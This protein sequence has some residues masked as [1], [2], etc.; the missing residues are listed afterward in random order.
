MFESNECNV[1]LNREVIL[2]YIVDAKKLMK[3]YVKSG[4]YPNKKLSVEEE[5]RMND[6]LALKIF[7]RKNSALAVGFTF[8]KD[9]LNLHLVS[10]MYLFSDV[11][12][13]INGKTCTAVIK[14]F[15]RETIKQFANNLVPIFRDRQLSDN[16]L[17]STYTMKINYATELKKVENFIEK[18]R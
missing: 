10:A 18:Y 6:E 14:D 7:E 9:S 4:Y 12:Y 5:R 8:N 13:E 11:P 3:E 16:K 2:G 17:F 1:V 15:D